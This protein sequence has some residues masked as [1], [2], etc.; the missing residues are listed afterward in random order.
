M[1]Q[2]LIHKITGKT[3]VFSGVEPLEGV[4]LYHWH[5]LV[6]GRSHPCFGD[7]KHAG[8][9]FMYDTVIIKRRERKENDFDY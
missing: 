4:H 1:N 6:N 3:I 2:I 7:K 9:E 5:F 8:K